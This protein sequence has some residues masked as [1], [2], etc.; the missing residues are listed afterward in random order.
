M[1]DSCVTATG[2][3]PPTVTPPTLATF[4]PAAPAGP[5]GESSVKTQRFFSIELGNVQTLVWMQPGGETSQ[6]TRVLTQTPNLCVCSWGIYTVLDGI[7]SAHYF[8]T[9]PSQVLPQPGAQ[10]AQLPSDSGA[11]AE[12]F[13]SLHTFFCYI[14]FKNVKELPVQACCDFQTIFLC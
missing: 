13:P 3:N 10:S 6:E 11:T 1:G 7:Q 4:A 2:A 5:A 9:V 8:A 14:Q 12:T